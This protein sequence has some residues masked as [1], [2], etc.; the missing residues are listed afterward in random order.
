M[1]SIN[2]KNIITIAVVAVVAT[3]FRVPLVRPLLARIP[4]VGK[5]A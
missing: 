4:V 5:Y 1:K 2:W 3:I